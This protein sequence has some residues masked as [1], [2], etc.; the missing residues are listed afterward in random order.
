SLSSDGDISIKSLSFRFPGDLRTTNSTSFLQ[1]GL[2]HDRLVSME[3]SIQLRSWLHNEHGS[4]SET[5]T[6]SEI[7]SGDEFLRIFNATDYLTSSHELYAGF[8]ID[9]SASASHVSLS[10]DDR[11]EFAKNM[12]AMDQSLLTNSDLS[13]GNN[14]DGEYE[15]LKALGLL[16]DVDE[17]K[18][19]D[20]TNDEFG[21]G[22]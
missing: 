4:S 10:Y 2:R 9:F 18:I 17:V 3:L 13:A 6:P 20:D 22:N 1:S 7:F 14:L 21:T 8:G 19:D 5:L 16:E 11:E 12:N 15:F